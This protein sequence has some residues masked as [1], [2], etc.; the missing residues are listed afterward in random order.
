MQARCNYTSTLSSQHKQ[1]GECPANVPDT[2]YLLKLGPGAIIIRCW[3]SEILTP[4]YS[5]CL[6]GRCF[7]DTL[8]S[9]VAVMFPQLF[10]VSTFTSTSDQQRYTSCKGSG[11]TPPGQVGNYPRIVACAMSLNLPTGS[12]KDYLFSRNDILEPPYE[13]KGVYFNEGGQRVPSEKKNNLK[14]LVLKR[15][16]TRWLP[17]ANSWAVRSTEKP[18]LC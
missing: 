4:N 3:N 1:I 13:S 11:P 18:V 12:K 14:N 7:Q 5:A 2:V 9:P 8:L 10:L 16:C 6:E 17:F 15:V